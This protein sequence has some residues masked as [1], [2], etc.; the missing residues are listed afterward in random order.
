MKTAEEFREL[1]DRIDHRIDLHAA[2]ANVCPTCD[3]AAALRE[4]AEMVRDHEAMKKL[5]AMPTEDDPVCLDWDNES[6]WA[7]ISDRKRAVWRNDPADAIL[8]DEPH[9]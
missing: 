8:G 1:A 3:A 4:A 9:E 6:G 5:R 7:I 2:D